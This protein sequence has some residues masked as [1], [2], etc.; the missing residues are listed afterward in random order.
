MTQWWGAGNGRVAGRLGI[1]RVCR[2]MSL[3]ISAQ[4]SH[5]ANPVEHGETRR[6]TDDA[7]LRP[8]FDLSDRGIREIELVLPR[9][10]RVDSER[11]HERRLD[12]A[13]VGHYG[14]PLSGMPSYDF[15]VE[16]RHPL[17]ELGQRNAIGAGVV[18]MPRQQVGPAGGDVS[19][20]RSTWISASLSSTE[21]FRPIRSAITVAVSSARA[22]G[23][24]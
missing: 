4:A 1:V 21:T 6:A 8:E 19:A 13:R 17:G 24:L 15:V 2:Q 18:G 7:A 5:I 11:P 16:V 23:L 3:A 22:R 12:C 20:S 10:S 14:N 9:A